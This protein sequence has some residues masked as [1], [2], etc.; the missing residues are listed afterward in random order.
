MGWPLPSASNGGLR[1]TVCFTAVYGGRSSPAPVPLY[2]LEVWAWAAGK[3]AQAILRGFP[4]L[5]WGSRT[6][7]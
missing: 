5:P 7:N 4:L 1:D 3:S 6:E 2:W